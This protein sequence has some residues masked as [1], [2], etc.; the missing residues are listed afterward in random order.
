MKNSLSRQDRPLFSVKK[1]HETQLQ[2]S[3]HLISADRLP[4]EI[5]FVAG[6]DVA[7]TKDMSIGAACVLKYGTLESLE[8]K[9]ALCP[10]R[11]PYIPTLLS[12]REIEPIMS[13][14]NQ[15]EL[16]PDLFLVDG[17]G[18]AHPYHCGLASHL[19]LVMGKPTIGVAKSRLFGEIENDEH[20]RDFAYLKHNNEIIGAAIKIRTGSQPI[21]V[22]VGHMISLRTAIKIVKECTRSHRLPEPLL[23]AHETATDQKR[24]INITSKNNR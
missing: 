15:L 13:S 4:P 19:G 16:K 23:Q 21:Y 7:Y 22:S 10:T 1:A 14:I 17:Q 20:D 6:V 5:R 2:M 9:V 8:Y 12:F 18:L 11:M 24:K 3:K